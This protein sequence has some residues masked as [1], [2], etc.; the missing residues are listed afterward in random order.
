MKPEAEA[1]VSN[2]NL[3]RKESPC[4]DWKCIEHALLRFL[5]EQ[6]VIQSG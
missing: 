5:E 6:L 3:L 4:K 1:A 2:W